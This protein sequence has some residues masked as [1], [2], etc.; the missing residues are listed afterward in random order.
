MPLFNVLL[1]T[2]ENHILIYDQ[3]HISTWSRS[4]KAEAILFLTYY[5]KAHL[6]RE[7]KL[8]TEKILWLF[9]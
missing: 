6:T 7:D 8:K 1:K 2:W 9:I 5:E 4:S 3:A